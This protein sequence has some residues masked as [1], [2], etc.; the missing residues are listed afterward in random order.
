V[1]FVCC[2]GGCWGGCG[3]VCVNLGCF[4]CCGPAI[5][6]AIGQWVLVGLSSVGCWGWLGGVSDRSGFVGSWCVCVD[7][8][9]F[10]G[11]G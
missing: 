7:L 8:S 11:L 3:F 6:C 2:G 10:A 1:L 4:Y 5:R 9:V